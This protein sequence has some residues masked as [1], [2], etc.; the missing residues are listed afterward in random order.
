MFGEGSERVSC[1][2]MK[3]THR[4]N[5]W[6][7]NTLKRIGHGEPG[8]TIFKSILEFKVVP[9]LKNKLLLKNDREGKSCFPDVRHS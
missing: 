3:K 7:N 2:S 6:K 1:V 9:W 4:K 5:N 8:K